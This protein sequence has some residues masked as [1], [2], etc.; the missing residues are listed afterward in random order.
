MEVKQGLPE[1]YRQN[2]AKLYEEAF[3]QKFSPVIKD[4][5]ER[6]KLLAES[7]N[8]PLSFVAIEADELCGIA[9]FYT[10]TESFTGGTKL[11]KAFK[12]LGVWKGTKA[13][14]LLTLF[15]RSPDKDQLLMD[16]IC[17]DANQRGKGIGSKLLDALFV[18]AKEQGLKTV[19][20]DVIDSNPRA[21]KLYESKGFK[22]TKV[23]NVPF[24]RN[25]MGFGKVTTMVKTL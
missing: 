19:K 13:I 5:N 16:G 17:V 15:K 6:V 11:W 2:A 21:R 10:Q 1:S 12:T 9:G 24:M 14:I 3:R 25:I 4:Q 23:K 7:F 20:L 18:Y 22:A 8:P